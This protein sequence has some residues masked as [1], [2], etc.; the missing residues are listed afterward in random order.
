MVVSKETI[1]GS[2]ILFNVT[3]NGSSG[4]YDFNLSGVTGE[5]LLQVFKTSSPELF[6]FSDWVTLAGS[7]FGDVFTGSEGVVWGLLIIIVCACLGFFSIVAGIFGVIVG[8]IAMYSLG[9]SSVVS[10]SG[11]IGLVVVAIALG[12]KIRR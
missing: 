12:I 5:V 2:L 10:F 3:Q 9:L 6:S 8:L 1:T 4:S 11:L 7:V